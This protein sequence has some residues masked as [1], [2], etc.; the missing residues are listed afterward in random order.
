MCAAAPALNQFLHCR[1]EMRRFVAS[2]VARAG[3]LDAHFADS[4]WVGNSFGEIEVAVDEVVLLL[5]Q[6]LHS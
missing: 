4:H 3:I 5:Q 1:D 2:F 6:L